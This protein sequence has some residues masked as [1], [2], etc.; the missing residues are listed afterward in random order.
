MSMTISMVQP[1]I[2]ANSLLSGAQ[3]IDAFSV[4][5]DAAPLTARQA[6]ERMLG[7]S[8]RWVELLMSLRDMLVTPFGLTTAKSARHASVDKIGIFPVLSETP[9]RLIAGFNDSHL[10]FRVVV[11]VA[12]A[13]AG[14]RVTAT[15]VVLMHNWLGHIYLT[16]IKPF[17]RLVVRSMLKQLLS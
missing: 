4:T 17:H 14:Q 11:D 12:A 1:T 15:T 13:G 5:R 10:D 9:E 6:A 8:P 16:V 7:H 2:D 3:F